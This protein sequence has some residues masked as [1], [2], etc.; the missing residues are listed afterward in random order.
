[1][2]KTQNQNKGKR[3]VNCRLA[4]IPSSN[5]SSSHP[6][7]FFRGNSYEKVGGKLGSLCVSYLYKNRLFKTN[8][9]RE[10]NLKG[11]L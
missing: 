3:K 5:S 6:E 8:W 9:G 1:M 7:K 11:S 4:Q 10:A 2:N